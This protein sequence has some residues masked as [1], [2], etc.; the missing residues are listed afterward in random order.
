MIEIVKKIEFEIYFSMIVLSAL[1]LRILIPQNPRPELVH[2]DVLMVE[3]ANNILLGNWLGEWNSTSYGGLTL[4]KPPGYSIFLAL[5]M[6]IGIA[7]AVASMIIYLI[8]VYFIVKFGLRIKLKSKLGVLAIS[9]FAFNPAFYSNEASLIYRDILIATIL[10]VVFAISF[11]VTQTK[12]KLSKIIY[13]A[14]LNGLVIGFSA[15]LKDDIKYLCLIVL[16]ITTIYIYLQ[17]NTTKNTSFSIFIPSII[18]I[19]ISLVTYSALNNTIKAINY[20][21]YGVYLT[22]DNTSGAFSDMITILSS[23]KSTN[24]VPDVFI[25]ESMIRNAA[26]VSPKF[27]ELFPYLSSENLW[28]DLMCV[29]YSF[30][31]PGLQPYT[32]EQIRDAMYVKNLMKTPIEFQSNSK[33][34]ANDIRD[35]CKQEIIQCRSSIK[36]PGIVNNYPKISEKF[37]LDSM[38]KLQKIL[39]NWEYVTYSTPGTLSSEDSKAWKDIPGIKWDY[40]KHP[41]SGSSLGLSELR[42]FMIWSYQ[43]ITV[44]IIFILF[45]LVRSEKFKI[46]QIFTDKNF[47]MVFA[48]YI[49]GSLI[50]VITNVSGWMSLYSPSSYLLY[51]S[52]LIIYFYMHAIKLASNQS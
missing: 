21:K 40:P 34:I 51:F 47:A 30:C 4:L 13:L 17:N 37:T 18:F 10:T 20:N 36:I 3:L 9:L 50:M 31:E 6:K 33:K 25:D 29:N 7:P 1:T 46:K 11:Y 27:S 12:Y 26:N 28:K 42:K 41:I 32:N 45:W 19:G 35:A 38:F 39:L 15:L 14:C 22:Q 49:T 16:T 44:M 5:C 52:T 23:I 2:D 24:N 43:L 48:I 8:S